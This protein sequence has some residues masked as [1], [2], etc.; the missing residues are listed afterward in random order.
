MTGSLSRLL[1][2]RSIAVIGGRP[3]AEVIRQSDLIGFDGEIWP[4]HPKLDQVEGRRA[5]RSVA[6]LPGAPD[7]AFVAVNRA[8]TVEVVGDLA[9]HGAGGAVCYASGFSESGADGNSLQQALIAAAGAMPFLGPNCYGLIN[10]LDNAL[11]WP[12]QHGG[13]RVARGVAIVTQSGNIG[14]N[15]TMQ[16]RALPIAYLATLGNQAAVG[17]SAVIETLL[18]D[19]RVTTI[20]LHIEGID[21]PRAL[22][23][24]SARARRRGVPIVALKTGRSAAGAEL[25]VS[26][27]ASMGGADAAVDAFFR[28]IGIVRV[29]TIPI[30]LETLKLLHFGGPLTGRAIASMS[31]SGGEAALIADAVEESP[32]DFRPLDTTQAA[33]V[34]ATLPEL[35][36]ISNP[37]DYHTFSWRN[38]PA[39]TETFSAMMAADYDLTMPLLDFPRPDRCDDADWMISAEA[40]V[41][42]AQ[43][44]GRRGAVVAT[45][46]DAFPEERAMALAEAGIAPLFGMDDALAAASA[47]ADAGEFARMAS[48]PVRLDPPPA[49]R[50]AA[51][52]EWDGKQILARYGLPVPEGLLAASA[53]Q[54]VAAAETI[55]FPVVVKAVGAQIAHKTELGAVRLDL[56]DGAAVAESASALLPLAGRVSAERMVSD[57]VAELIVGV[58]RD[59][60]LGPVLLVGSGGILAELVG[61]RALMAMP[62]A[63]HEIYAAIAG[64]KAARLLAGHR[65]KPAGDIGATIAAILAIQAFALDHLDRLAELDV[66]PLMVRPKGSG[67]VAVDALISLGGPE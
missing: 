58:M 12:D 60:A 62:A 67:V 25:T 49:G 47:A 6:E 13:R 34:A 42:A 5:Y 40:M 36:T 16:K 27:T 53:A 54:A 30:F 41:A 65:G 61:D 9:A 39:L 46:P 45:L 23:A 7:A 28:R 38:G 1:R 14:L 17:L 52:S 57:A 48:R 26:H 37:L 4:V 29:Q 43:R 55:G 20:G 50:C 15:F 21:D 59:P 63:A 66:N 18:D 11:L 22:A 33:R 56:T 64:L 44:T 2:P 8:L 19:D 3:A 51:L 31:C 10:Y 32:L 35:V 24:V